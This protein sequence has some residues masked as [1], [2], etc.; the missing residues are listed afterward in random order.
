MEINIIFCKLT[1]VV[2]GLFVYFLMCTVI[3][4][5]TRRSFEI[6]F[7]YDSVLYVAIS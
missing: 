1:N 6:D 4:K 2:I 5:K 3:M 7:Y